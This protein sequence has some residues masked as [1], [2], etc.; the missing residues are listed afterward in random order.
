MCP[1]SAGWNCLIRTKKNYFIDVIAE[2]KSIS[3]AV[4]QLVPPKQL[5]K[6]VIQM[7]PTNFKDYSA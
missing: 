7:H 4:F 1:A 3:R 5:V 6:S 2:L